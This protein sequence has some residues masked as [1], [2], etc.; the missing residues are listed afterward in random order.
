MSLKQAYILIHMPYLFHV[1]FERSSGLTFWTWPRFDLLVLWLIEGAQY[2]ITLVTIILDDTQLRQDS[3]AARDN[4]TGSDQLVQVE[5]SDE[6]WK[7][8]QCT[9]TEFDKNNAL[10]LCDIPIHLYVHLQ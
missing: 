5:L 6:K 7:M 4:A 8:H 9:T 1:D 2:V 10:Y 3:G